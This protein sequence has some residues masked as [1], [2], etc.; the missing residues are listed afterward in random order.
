[1]KTISAA[2]VAATLLAASSAAHAGAREQVSLALQSTQVNFANPAS[3]AQF[4]KDLD[5][6]I[7]AACNPGDRLGADLSPDFKC[8]REMTASAEPRV[9]A[10]VLAATSG[11]R[12]AASALPR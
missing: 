9:Q 11:T 5:R 3:V 2:L 1:M 8:R 4:R 7:A 10:L 6:Q 12:V